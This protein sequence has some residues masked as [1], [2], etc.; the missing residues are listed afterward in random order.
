[1]DNQFNPH[2]H[3]PRPFLMPLPF[4]KTFFGKPFGRT[5]IPP[6]T[7]KNQPWPTPHTPIK[8]GIQL[9]NPVKAFPFL[10]SLKGGNHLKTRVPKILLPWEN[11]HPNNSPLKIMVCLEWL[12]Q[13]F[14]GNGNQPN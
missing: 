8:N 10:Q 6:W 9:A 3:G 11:P 12:N 2:N 4:G 7:P 1:M 14:L 5:P 13:P